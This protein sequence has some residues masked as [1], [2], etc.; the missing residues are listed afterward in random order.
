MDIHYVKIKVRFELIMVSLPPKEK[1][2]Y[3]QD[4]NLDMI[5]FPNL[6]GAIIR[7]KY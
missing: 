3:F 7:P 2:L 6:D 4:D 1:T 5:K